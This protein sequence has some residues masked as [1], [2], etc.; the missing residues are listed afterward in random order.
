MNEQP[1][2]LTGTNRTERR[3]TLIASELDL[4]KVQIVALSETRLAETRQNSLP[5]THS[6]GSDVDKDR[7]KLVL[8]SS[9]T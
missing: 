5:A 2:E 8:S 7:Q 3:T 6:S 1:L 9:P 4:Y